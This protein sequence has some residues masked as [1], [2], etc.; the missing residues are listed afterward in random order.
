MPSTV[1]EEYFKKTGN[2]PPRPLLVK[3]LERVS[4]KS[5]NALDIGAGA[6]N[7]T[8]YLLNN[9]WDVVAI[10]SSKEF[11]KYA[12]HVTDK[13]FQAVNLPIEKYQF[14]K[15]F[16]LINAQFVLS[17]IKKDLFKHALDQIISSL[18][19]GGIFCGNFFGQEDERNKVETQMTFLTRKEV[20]SLFKDF[21]IISFNEVRENAKTA[22]G[23]MKYWH[24][25]EIIA[26]KK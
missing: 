22:A 10:D 24:V 7:D 4:K 25:H 5:G 14:N 26:M 23:K 15:T 16:S 21:Q 6:L 17:F 20:E 12:T 3:A 11:M 18:E 13:K 19:S 9:G 2:N 8:K 1:W